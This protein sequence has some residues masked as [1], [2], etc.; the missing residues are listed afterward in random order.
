[1]QKIKC[2]LVG[3]VGCGKTCLLLRRIHKVYPNT[4]YIP[5]VV[6]C[7]PSNIIIDN[8]PIE[9]ELHDTGGDV[10]DHEMRWRYTYQQTDVF[11]ICYSIA[12]DDSM[13]NIITKWIPR[14]T[15][16][17]T[18]AP[19]II[20]GLKNDLRN[21]PNTIEETEVKKIAAI[22]G[23]ECYMECSSLYGTNVDNI[24]NTT[25]QILLQDKQNKLKYKHTVPEM[26]Y[27][28]FDKTENQYILKNRKYFYNFGIYHFNTFIFTVFCL[29]IDIL[30]QIIS[31]ITMQKKK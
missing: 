29:F 10:D 30:I 1:M 14:V 6:D 18:G 5:T 19:Y 22:N 16:Y 31:V 25:I 28:I 23:A 12:S 21:D 9:F 15:K 17:V 2:V 7:H 20:I 13:R 11:L 26:T 4:E 8:N 3:D 27:Y 24:F